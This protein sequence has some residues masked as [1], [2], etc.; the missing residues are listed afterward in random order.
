VSMPSGIRIGVDI[1]GTFTDII[2]VA[3]DGTIARKKVPSTPED[4]SLAIQHGFAALF[5]ENGIASRDVAA[6]VHGMTVATNAILEGHGATT[7]LITTAGFR[8]VLELCRIRLP[9]LYNLAYE[10]V[11]PLVPRR[12][13]FEV[14]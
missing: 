7:A 8:D 9:E 10:R 2:A 13:R 11:K 4:Y 14:R 3:A 12:R 6:V 1:G 5:E